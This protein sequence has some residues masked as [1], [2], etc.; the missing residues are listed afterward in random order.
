MAPDLDLRLPHPRSGL[1]GRAGARVH[2]RQ[3]VRVRRARA[4]GRARR[5]RVRA[6]AR[7]SSS[8]RTSTSS[9][10]SPSTAPPAASGRAG[11]ASATARR[12]SARCRCGSTRRPR[13][14]RSPRSSP[15]STSSAPRSRRWPACSAARRA[16]T[17][18][19]WT[20]RSRCRPRRRRGIA[21]RTQQV[22]ANETRV[23]NVA[24]PLGGSWY[25]EALTDEME[26]QAEELFAHIDELGDGSMLD[27]AVRGV[28]EGW[29]Q[30]EIADSA[31]ELERKLN[32]GPARRRRRE[33]VPRGQRRAAAADPAHRA[34][35][36]RGAAPPA[37]EGAARARRGRGRTA[38]SR[39][40]APTPAEPDVNLMPALLDAVARATRRSAR[41]STRWPTCSAAGSRPADLS[42]AAHHAPTSS[43]ASSR[44]S[45]SCARVDGLDRDRA[46]ARFYRKSQA[47]LH[48]HVDGDDIYADV[49]LDGHDVRAHAGDDEGR[50]DARCV[51]RSAECSTKPDVRRWIRSC[52]TAAARRRASCPTTKG[53]RCTT[54]GVDGGRVRAAARD[55][56]LLRQ[57]GG[58]PRR[59]G[60]RGGHG[61]VHRRPPPRLGGEPGRLGAPRP[62]GRRSR[63]RAHGHAAVLP[64]HDRSAPDS[65]TSSSR[66]SVTRCRSRARGARRSGFL[67]IDGGHAEDVAMAD[68]EALVAARRARRHARD[69][70]RVRGSRPT[71]ARPRST[72]GKRAVADGFD[73]VST[74][75]SLRVLRA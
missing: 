33:R 58:V 66:S 16:C 19:R 18:T 65:K 71:A 72:S 48:F 25:V 41:S 13:A 7:R 55:R 61:A 70:R 75:G 10:R 20:R 68:Y 26:R 67:F 63:D 4:A 35:G 23:A 37:R 1:D 22:I 51:A 74:T 11:C 64:A 29:F 56:H 53:S 44:C 15:R 50:A 28:E 27:G 43:T 12:P 30:G 45:T 39:G 36:R 60:A 52:S 31:Y 5:R 17:P 21:L 57:V 73:P 62:R 40:C 8:T 47:F 46:R 69:P 32:G 42:D 6:A 38:R 49:R 9:R 2:A 3:R 14:C 59:G 54:P 34:R 24:D